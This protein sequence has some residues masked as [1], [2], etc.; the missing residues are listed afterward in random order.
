MKI[1]KNLINSVLVIAATLTMSG[2]SMVQSAAE[3]PSL[4]AQANRIVIGLGLVRE[5][6]VIANMPLSADAVWPEELTQ[7]M[8][9]EN[10]ILIDAAL[11]KDPYVATH[12]LT[13]AYQKEKLEANA[14]TKALPV[15][16]INNMTY[17]TLN[18]AIVLYGQNTSAWPTFFDL[19]S[20]FSKFHEFQDGTLKEVKATSG[21][22][23]PNVTEAVI[24][25]MPT[26]LQK[27]LRD[28]KEAMVVSFKEVAKAKSDK[29]ELETTLSSKDTEGKVLSESEIEEI[30]S[31]IATLE[32]EI[33]G[34]E[35]NA[36]EKETIY[37]TQLDEATEALKSDIELDEEQVKLAK[38]I[39]FVSSAIKDGALEA[40]IGFSTSVGLIAALPVIQ[41]FPKELESLATA[42]QYIPIEKQGLYDMRIV[43]IGNN[44]IYSL[45][46]LAIGTY[47]AIKQAVL[48]GK[49]ETVAEIIVEADELRK[50]EEKARLEDEQKAKEEAEK[51]VSET[52]NKA[53]AEK[54]AS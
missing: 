49:Y 2:C 24:S 51:L 47:Y 30:T 23:Y 31:K 34:K 45:P 33:T 53:E 21:N 6:T 36:D 18:R 37:L 10:K 20:E 5:N 54:S 16:L 46:A 17:V 19:N 4:E 14:L 15:P 8:T 13:D 25:L 42:K 41:N 35:V 48:A 52:Q 28:S 26:N 32:T 43:R 50:E 9:E 38:N 7:A 22:L 39:L 40:G 3:V 44:A 29:G 11:A 12:H 1:S 27:D